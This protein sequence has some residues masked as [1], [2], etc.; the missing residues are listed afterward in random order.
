MVCV[1]L[2]WARVGTILGLSWAIFGYVGAFLATLA[3]YSAYLEPCWAAL[4]QGRPANMAG[5]QPAQQ[6]P[7]QQGHPPGMAEQQG[8]TLAQQQALKASK[9]SKPSQCLFGS[10]NPAGQ[11]SKAP[12]IAFSWRS[13]LPFASPQN[14]P[15][16]PN[17]IWQ[18]QPRPINSFFLRSNLPFAGPQALQTLQM[19]FGRPN[20]SGQGTNAPSIAFSWRSSLPFATL[21]NLPNAPNAFLGA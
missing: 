10:P 15:N 18:P 12:S 5:G 14:Q 6:Q 2:C 9:P 20:P 11:G 21:H 8:H 4:E 17:A 1:R 16:A 19:P 7:A 3:P 13:S